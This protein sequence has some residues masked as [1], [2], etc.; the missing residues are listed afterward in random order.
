[1]LIKD[2]DI[3]K[4][5]K[6]L[7]SVDSDLHVTSISFVGNDYTLIL[8]KPYDDSEERHAKTHELLQEIMQWV[9][10]N[11]HNPN[12]LYNPDRE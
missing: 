1:M 3:H 11:D 6:L 10:D 8:N 12:F 2:V 7:K 4:I 9:Y 5:E